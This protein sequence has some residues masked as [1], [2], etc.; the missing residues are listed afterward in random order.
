MKISIIL[1]TEKIK[2]SEPNISDIYFIEQGDNNKFYITSD[3]GY[4]GYEG[5]GYYDLEKA[6]KQAKNLIKNYFYDRSEDNPK[7]W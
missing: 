4:N 3:N 7:G 5:D 6:L 2:I 1:Q